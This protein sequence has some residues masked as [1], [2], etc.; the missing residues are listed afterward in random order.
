[1]LVTGVQQNESVIHISDV[2]ILKYTY[3]KKT[4]FYIGVWPINI[5]A[6]VSGGQP[7]DSAI[8]LHVSILPPNTPPIQAATWHWAEFPVLYTVGPCWFSTLNIAE[9]ICLYPLF[10]S[11]F[12]HIGHYRVLSR[13]PCAM[14]L[15]FL[16]YDGLMRHNF[17]LSQGRSVLQ[18][19]F[20]QV[21]EEKEKQ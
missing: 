7:K 20:A 15:I 4:S 12:P 9:W 21:W 8:H 11:F 18:F 19:T 16:T 14:T 3:L 1:M 2:C 10:F 13:V 17:I 6:I 5:A